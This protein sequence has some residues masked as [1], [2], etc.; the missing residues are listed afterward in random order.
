VKR[1]KVLLHR[2]RSTA[3]QK[4]VPRAE[5]RTATTRRT[6]RGRIRRR[7]YSSCDSG[8][9]EESSFDLEKRVNFRTFCKHKVV[10]NNYGCLQNVVRTSERQNVR[11]SERQNV[12]NMRKGDNCWDG[13]STRDADESVLLTLC[14]GCETGKGPFASGQKHSDS[15]SSSSGRGADSDDEENLEGRKRR[16]KYAS[17][18]SGKEEE[19]SFDLEKRTN[20]K[21]SSERQNGRTAERQNGRM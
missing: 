10:E 7:K 11:T 8:K 18:D 21:T 3:T 12:R 9:E 16:R 5:E 14:T 15:E 13:K 20:F 1:G 17:C 2:G 6:S 4:A 19:S